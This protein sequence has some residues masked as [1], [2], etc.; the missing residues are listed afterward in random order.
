M[1]FNNNFRQQSP[2]RSDAC[3]VIAASLAILLDIWRYDLPRGASDRVLSRRS[4][5]LVTSRRSVEGRLEQLHR[6]DRAIAKRSAGQRRG[7]PT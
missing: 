2:R 5:L 1:V 4:I 7:H 3:A 6:P